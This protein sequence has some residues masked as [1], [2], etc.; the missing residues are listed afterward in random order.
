MLT[1]DVSYLKTREAATH[2]MV[3]RLTGWGALAKLAPIRS[4]VCRSA[5]R[6]WPEHDRERAR[7]A[8][9]VTLRRPCATPRVC[10]RKPGASKPLHL[11]AMPGL[12]RSSAH[13]VF[14]VGYAA[15]AL[16]GLPGRAGGERNQSGD[17]PVRGQA[18]GK[19]ALWV[20]QAHTCA[21]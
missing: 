2:R 4:G 1:T 20:R 6:G 9:H 7:L 5:A 10:G 18:A 8:V 15:P 13:V 14:V 17:I 16:D 11:G 19:L 21:L 3:F 12:T